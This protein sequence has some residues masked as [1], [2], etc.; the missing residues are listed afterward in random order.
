MQSLPLFVH[1]MPKP[2]ATSLE[3]IK[4]K[5]LKTTDELIDYLAGLR[6]EATSL[7]P[8][9]LLIQNINDYIDQTLETVEKNQKITQICTHFAEAV[10]YINMRS[11]CIGLASNV[12][13][14]K[15]NVYCKNFEEIYFLKRKNF[16][17]MN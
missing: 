13:L 16:K 9:M 4:F 5:Y 17:F 2:D 11:Y 15:E 1:N 14:N 6:L 10:S 8:C 12:Q 7:L 3:L